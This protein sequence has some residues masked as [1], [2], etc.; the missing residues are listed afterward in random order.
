[1]YLYMYKDKLQKKIVRITSL[2][3]VF[4][5]VFGTAFNFLPQPQVSKNGQLSFGSAIS[6]AYA[7]TSTWNG[8]EWTL[9]DTITIDAANIDET[10]TNFPVY[11]DLSDLSSQFWNTVAAGGGDIRVTNNSNTELPREVVSASTT[12][13]TGEL[14]FKADSISSS[15]DTVFKI[16]YNGSTTAAYANDDTYGTQNV[17]NDYAIVWH[18]NELEQSDS[19]GNFDDRVITGG[20]SDPILDSNG[21]VVMDANDEFFPP[22]RAQGLTATDWS[23]M[24]FWDESGNTTG[25]SLG[26]GEYNTIRLRYMDVQ[27]TELNTFD[28]KSGGGATSEISGAVNETGSQIL[29]ITY[30]DS[31]GIISVYNNGQLRA[32]TTGQAPA[33]GGWDD[34][35]VYRI[36]GT[37]FE[38]RGGT[39]TRSA[40]Y[41]S[42]QWVNFSTTTDFYTAAAYVPAPENTITIKEVFSTNGTETL[43]IPDGVISVD[44]K[45]WGAGGGAGGGYLAR[46]IQSYGG[47]GGAGG[48]ASGTIDVSNLSALQIRVGDAGKGGNVNSEGGGGGDYSGVFTTTNL[49]ILM[50]GGGGAGGG[51]GAHVSHTGG[52]GGA[53]GGENGLDGGDGVG[54]NEGIGG[55]GGSQFTGGAF[56]SGNNGNDGAA[57]SAYSGGAGAN[58]YTTPGTGSAVGGKGGSYFGGANGGSNYFG[59]GGGGSGYYGGGGAEAAGS[60][61]PWPSAGG[62]GGG[63]SYAST[64][65]ATSYTL[66]AGSG[67]TPPNTADTDYV[68]DRGTGGLGR[69]GNAGLAGGD[70]LVVVSYEIPG[71]KN[72]NATDWTSYD[73]ITIDADQVDATLTDFPVYVNL[74]DLS[75]SFW[76]TISAGGTDIRVTTAGGSPTELPREVVFASTTLETGEL[77]FKAN[78]ISSTT[79]TSFRIYYNGTTTLDYATDATYGAENVWTNN[80]VGVWHLGEEGNNDTGGYK[81]STS[82]NNDG[83]GTS[84]TGASGV[85]GAM[86][87]GQ[88]FDGANDFISIGDT[89]LT[90]DNLTISTWL[91]QASADKQA[92]DGVIFNRSTSVSGINVGSCQNVNSVGY[93][94]NGQSDTYSWTGGPVYPSDQW[95]YT[96]FVLDSTSASMYVNDSSSINSVSHSSSILDNMIFGADTF[97]T[98]RY[99]KGNLDEVRI[100][101]TSRSTAWVKAEYTNQNLATDFYSVDYVDEWNNSSW[102]EYDTITIYADHVEND[103]TDFPVYVDLADL[104]SSFWGTVHSSGADIRVTTNDG[105][106]LELSREVVAINKGTNK[107]ELHFK[108]NLISSTTDTT[109]R[110]YYRGNSD[111]DYPKSHRYGPQEVWSNGY[112]G[113]WHLGEGYST[114]TNFYKDSTANGYHGTMTDANSNSTATQGP[115]G[116]ALDFTAED[117]YITTAVLSNNLVST[118]MT[119]SGWTYSPNNPASHAGYF[120]LRDGTS[121]FYVLQLKSTNNLEARFANSAGTAYDAASPI[122]V[123][124]PNQWNYSTLVLDGSTLRYYDNGVAEG[125]K[126]TAGSYTQTNEALT[127]GITSTMSDDTSHD[128]VRLATV[129][130]SAAWVKAEYENQKNTNNFYGVNIAPAEVWNATDWTTYDTITIK[131]DQVDATLTDFPV[132]VDLANLSND[133]WSTTPSDS[134]FVAHDIRVTTDDASPVELPREIVAASSAAKTGEIHFK[135]NSISSSVN[136]TFRIYYNGTNYLD[137]ASDDTY[138]AENV[139]TNDYVG[140]W[141]LGEDGNTTTGGYRDSTSFGNHGTGVSMTGASNVSGQVG[142]SQNFN[143]TSNQIKVPR[144]NELEPTQSLTYSLWMSRVG[145]QGNY[146]KPIW[147]GRNIGAP[148]GPYGIQFNSSSDTDVFMKITDGTTNYNTSAVTLAASAWSY[149][150]GSYDGSIFSGYKDGSLYSSSSVSISIGDYDSNGL[151]IGDRYE[152]GNPY[153]GLVDEVRIASTSRSAAW[154]KA[155]YTNQSNT[156]TFYIVNDEAVEDYSN[157]TSTQAWIVPDNVYEI[158]VKAWGAGGGGGS[159]NSSV[160]GVGGGGG[161]IEGTIAV[162]PGETL[163]LK[164]GG[165]GKAG[166]VGGGSGLGGLNGG[167]VGGAGCTS[168]CAGGGGGYSGIFRGSNPLFVAAGGGGG[169]L[170]YSAVGGYGGAGGGSVGASGGLGAATGAAGG[171]SQSTGGVAGTGYANGNTG[172]YLTGANGVR[173]SGTAYGTGGGG[174]GYYGGGSGAAGTGA[175]NAGGGGGSSF[176]TSTATA[177]STVS[178]SS[179]DA[180]NNTDGDYMS[181]V[182]TGGVGHVSQVPATSGGDGLVIITYTQLLQINI[183][184]SAGGQV[185]NAFTSSGSSNVE[186]FSFQLSST[187]SSVNLTEINIGLMGAKGISSSNFS[188]IA[189]YKDVNNNAVYDSGT[190]TLVST[191]TA[192]LTGQNGRITFTT[193][194]TI[195]GVSNYLVVGDT[196][197]IPLGG[198]VNFS[199]YPSGISKRN[200]IVSGAVSSI[201][202]VRNSSGGGGS[203]YGGG[204]GAAAVGGEPP[205]GDGDVGGGGS[206]GGG[207]VDDG[208][209]PA[210]DGDVGGGGGGGGGGI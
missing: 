191:S 204:G 195:A 40:A 123:V 106:P 13:Q 147:Y 175:V 27:R 76:S 91:K 138:G 112:V 173:Y 14:H 117:D 128:E 108:A 155:E 69:S 118:D 146:A 170:G 52:A 78:S 177:T 30:D 167:G 81:D 132:Y 3:V 58:G 41:V 158:N 15:V 36:Q 50:S 83:T 21:D 205:A 156:K 145:A 60:G 84:M 137:Y 67:V 62:A 133:F 136:T 111:P 182:G 101:S 51:G 63:S 68:S 24:T 95:F 171:G 154:V 184:D 150:V 94:W 54:L 97:S 99:F 135:A 143:G 152:S 196:S 129:S 32:T 7:A 121:D 98:N 134:R 86:G 34:W 38:S 187:T 18:M 201:Q 8:S 148:Y 42:A 1:M 163:T 70:G 144:S 180:G 48:F 66:T 74:S 59:G 82:N 85:S 120:G 46:G 96:S 161:F 207:G 64:T 151:S 110:I 49:P 35:R 113:V 102:T 5:M 186:L 200:L 80:Y 183:G 162:T 206:G 202:H 174:G 87:G 11:V 57:G 75:S 72:W 33:I 189:L 45:V 43:V 12:A 116:G 44:V 160:G 103:L 198:Y 4:T 90:L 168:Y 20:Y 88:D 26:E 39:T 37:H 107:G 139:W 192:L 47:D 28:I 10:L 31:A 131:A 159:T 172:S 193:D 25:G 22:T 100:A 165:G 169:G 29:F 122:P 126:A 104:S 16:W 178:G 92:C 61:S 17:W 141:H 89:G 6:K 53:G 93:H 166:L 114:D 119:L 179:R 55:K 197:D 115:V 210:G 194:L 190:D 23:M 105:S 181:G 209:P 140:V 130:R 71:P 185:S 203:Y 149:L 142:V 127:I 208:N 77:H 9:Y 19:T 79:D 109:F 124:T 73:T 56:G 153:S 2:L 164:V 176:A 188:N 199:L 125:T 65:L 157:A